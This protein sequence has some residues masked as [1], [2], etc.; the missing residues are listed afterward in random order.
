MNHLSHFAIHAIEVQ[1]AAKFYQRVFNWKSESYANA[2]V[3]KDEFVQ[4][5][6]EDHAERLQQNP[7][8]RAISKRS[9]NSPEQVLERSSVC[10]VQKLDFASLKLR[11]LHAATLI[12]CGSSVTDAGFKAGYQSTS[13]FVAAFRAE[14]GFRLE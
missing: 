14:L 8:D 12:G 10:F 7:S 3:S 9:A 1:R 11:L 6:G 2:G 4:L 5:F 13:A